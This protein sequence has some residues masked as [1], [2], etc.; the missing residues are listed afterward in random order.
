MRRILATLVLATPLLSHAANMPD[1]H[2][3][4]LNITSIS[5]HNGSTSLEVLSDK[6]GVTQFSTAVWQ[7]ANNV[8]TSGGWGANA[9]FNMD[10]N[11]APTAGYVITGFSI[12]AIS[13]GTLWTA[14]R[15]PE[16]NDS[17]QP[18]MAR[19]FATLNFQVDNGKLFSSDIYNF[20]ATAP[21]EV[22]ANN[23]SI[24]HAASFSF[25]SYVYAVASYAS[26]SDGPDKFYQIPSTAAASF[27]APILTI[28]TA[29]APV[30]E[31]ET[32]GM[33]LAGVGLIGIARR[34]AKR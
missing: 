19:N 13:S 32:W 18:G 33:W 4:T 11:I 10:L 15:P 31:P 34:R 24:D 28:Y 22:S 2:T 27:T 25:E 5:D 9:G 7:T 3:S 16:A 29:L 17:W 23:L 26:W 20:T 21:L 12:S 1:V 30:P 8:T 14:P 6:N